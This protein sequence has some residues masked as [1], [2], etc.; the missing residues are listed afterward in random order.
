MAEDRCSGLPPP[1]R[2]L[3]LVPPGARKEELLPASPW[4]QG[5]VAAARIQ[6]RSKLRGERLGS[7]CHSFLPGSVLFR[8]HSFSDSRRYIV[9]S[10]GILPRMMPVVAE[11]RGE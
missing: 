9:Q 6:E 3:V 8:A 11:E 1:L 10:G 4:G 2:S 7:Y 5:M